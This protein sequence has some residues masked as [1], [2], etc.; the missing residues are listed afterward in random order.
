V[1]Q[2]GK[3]NDT[4]TR[5]RQ[6]SIVRDVCHDPPETHGALG[7]PDGVHPVE[8]CPPVGRF[9]RFHMRH[10]YPDGTIG[11]VLGRVLI[12]VDWEVPGIQ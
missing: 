12:H 10:Y 8:R 9:P 11:A 6:R 2:L 1:S 5:L 7:M 4:R 3:W